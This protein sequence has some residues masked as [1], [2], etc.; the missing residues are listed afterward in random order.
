VSEHRQDQRRNVFSRD[1]VT[2]HH[3][4]ARLGCE[5]QKHRSPHAPAILDVPAYDL[6]RQRIFGACRSDQLDRVAAHGLGDRDLPDQPLKLHDLLRRR[7]DIDLGD[8]HSCRIAVHDLYFVVVGQV[9]EDDVEKKAVELRLGQR[10]C[11]LELDRVLRR[12]HEKRPVDTVMVAA[13]GY[14]ELLHGFEQGRLCL[15][16]RSIDL[17]GEQ[18]IGE[19]RA[20]NERPGPVSRRDVLFDDIGTRHIRGHEVRGELDTLEGQSQRQ[21]E[22]TD[23]QRL[24]RSRHA[25][26]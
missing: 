15:W 10:V 17:I 19:N 5:R 2:A 6:G 7:A 13:H 12:K 18:Y 16:R 24:R 3:Q 23:Q 1:V 9:V 20:R 21:C 11:P 14:G 25:R 26:N 22:R 4:R 8:I